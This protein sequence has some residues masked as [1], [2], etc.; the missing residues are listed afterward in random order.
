[1]KQNQREQRKQNKY[2]QHHHLDNKG[3]VNTLK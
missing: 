2:E 1:M 3:E